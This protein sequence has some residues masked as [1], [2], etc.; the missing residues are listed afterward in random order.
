MKEYILRSRD[1]DIVSYM[2]VNEQNYLEYHWFKDNIVIKKSRR[3]KCTKGQKV[4]Y[5][6]NI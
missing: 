6:E 4:L 5:W 3:L 1:S 2:I